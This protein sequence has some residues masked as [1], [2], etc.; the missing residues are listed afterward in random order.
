MTDETPEPSALQSAQQRLAHVCM[1]TFGNPQGAAISAFVNSMLLC[2]RLDAA[3][4]VLFGPPANASW[5]QQEAL[6][7]A[8]ARH[9]NAKADQLDSQVTKA[10]IMAPGNGAA[11]IR[12]S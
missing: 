12:P 9:M 2:A 10:R 8:I 5:T 7:A 4:E 6:E 1:Q 11:L 3:L